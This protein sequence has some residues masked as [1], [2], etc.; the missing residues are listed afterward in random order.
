MIVHLSVSLFLAFKGMFSVVLST[1][2][3]V[4]DVE[5]A[6]NEKAEKL[7][8]VWIFGDSEGVQ[9]HVLI[10]SCIIYTFPFWTWSLTVVQFSSFYGSVRESHAVSFNG[11]TL[12]LV[13]LY[14]KSIV[15]GQQSRSKMCFVSSLKPWGPELDKLPILCPGLRK[16]NPFVSDKHFVIKNMR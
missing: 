10:I 3:I 1:E 5:K 7:I 8:D 6:K 4:N 12:P 15:G 2:F 16:I 9:Y 13:L 11:R 14:V